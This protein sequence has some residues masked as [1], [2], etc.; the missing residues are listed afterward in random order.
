M[1]FTVSY[2]HEKDVEQAAALGRA[3]QVIGAWI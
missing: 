2:W 3:G 1:A